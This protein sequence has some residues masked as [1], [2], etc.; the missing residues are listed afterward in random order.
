MMIVH[1]QNHVMQY[2]IPFYTS[3]LL[4][5]TDPII[6]INIFRNVLEFRHGYVVNGLI[7]YMQNSLC[8]SQF[9]RF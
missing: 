6:N 2:Y 5:M 9:Q 1:V 8:V 4:Q 7:M 3:Y